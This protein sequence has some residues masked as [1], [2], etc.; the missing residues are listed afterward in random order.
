VPV[1]E[2]EQAAEHIPDQDQV[3]RAYFEVLGQPTEG[4]A[5]ESLFPFQ[6]DRTRDER[7]ESVYWRKYASAHADVHQRGC[8][9]QSKLNAARA[10]KGH[11]P[12]KYIGF[13]TSRVSGIRSVVSQRGHRLRVVHYEQFGDKAH[14]HIAVQPPEGTTVRNVKPNDRMELAARLVQL[15]GD[16][17]EHSCPDPGRPDPPVK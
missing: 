16:Y 6:Y 14:A 13:R 4:L 7:A 2:N 12:L 15:F 5:P 11:A 1:A 8:A 3:S 9:L 10:E 17:Q